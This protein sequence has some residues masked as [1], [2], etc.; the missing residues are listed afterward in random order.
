MHASTHRRFGQ[1][2]RLLALCILALSLAVVGVAEAK[3]GGGGGGGGGG[4]KGGGKGGK[5]A[6]VRVEGAGDSIM[7]GY[8][9]SCTGNT[10]FG[11]LICYASGE[12]PEHSFL[13]GSSASV[14]S[15][16]DRYLALDGRATGS[17]SASE[18]GSEMVDPAKNN[19]EAQANAIVA[20]ATQ[21]VRVIVELG[22]NDLCNRT[23]DQDLYTGEQWQAAVDA[24]LQ[25]LVNGLPDGSTVL[26][27]GVPRVQDLRAA[28]LERQ[29]ADSGVNCQ[30]FWSTYGVCE[31]ATATD[32]YL[33]AIAAKQ[34][35]Y[36][37]ILAERAQAFNADAAT[38]GVEVVAEYAGEFTSSVGTF[39]FGADDINGGDCFHPSI[40]GQNTLSEVIWGNNPF[41]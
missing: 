40:G 23:S 1:R 32:A 30:S 21:P 4:G 11:D 33:A 36:N 37:G 31:V 41:K 7:Q 20:A 17:K 28:G 13:D 34:Q 12:Q 24:G 19:F 18:S 22:G 16:L 29:A 3:K 5:P 14:T 38:T 2:S 39:A 6:P 27:A 26:L 9:A 35:Q 10:S 25:V 15:I 8:N